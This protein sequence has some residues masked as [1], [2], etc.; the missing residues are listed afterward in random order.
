[1]KSPDVETIEERFMREKLE[2]FKKFK[3][4]EDALRK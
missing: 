3:K 1:M 4:E 2:R